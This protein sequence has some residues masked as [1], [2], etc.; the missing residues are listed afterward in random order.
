M[1]EL[2]T[3]QIEVQGRV[4]EDELNVSG[5]I[6]IAVVSINSDSTRFSIRTDQ[7]GLIG[8]LRYLHTHG[9]IFLTIQKER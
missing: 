2:Y 8:M 6:E 5:P 9:L 4:V 3:Y 7:S 1:D